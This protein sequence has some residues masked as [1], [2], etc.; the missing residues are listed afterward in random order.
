MNCEHKNS[1]RMVETPETPFQGFDHHIHFTPFQSTH[2]I[3][4]QARSNGVVWGGKCH[5]WTRGY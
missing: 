2:S 4:K 3:P 1:T 5:P